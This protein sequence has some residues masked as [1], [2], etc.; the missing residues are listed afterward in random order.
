MCRGSELGPHVSCLGNCHVSLVPRCDKAG[1]GE[2]GLSDKGSPW[3]PAITLRSLDTVC[4]G[5][6]HS[7]RLVR[8]IER[9]GWRWMFLV[10]L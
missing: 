8:F 5:N 1:T 7:L 6:E 10:L 9:R 4:V 2:V 3:A